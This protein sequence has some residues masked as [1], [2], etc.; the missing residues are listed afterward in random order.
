MVRK[1]L[2]VSPTNM[3]TLEKLTWRPE[4]RKVTQLKAWSKNPRKITK[5]AF[6]KLK[7]R[8]VK[9]GFHDVV[10]IDTDNTV[11]SGNQRK[12]ALVE[13]GIK[14]VTVLLPSRKLTEEERDKV[15]LESNTNDGEWNFEDLQ[16][17]DIELLTDIGFDQSELEKIWDKPSEVAEDNFDVEKELQKIKVPRTKVGDLI[18]MGRHKLI[19]GDCQDP[20][21]LKRLFFGEKAAMIYSDPPYNINL[22]YDKGIGGKRNFGGHVND[23]RTDKEYEEFLRKTMAAALSVANKDSHWFYY[24]SQLYVWQIQVLFRELGMENKSICIWAKNVANPVP[25]IAFNRSYEPVVYGTRGK[26]FLAKKINSLTEFMNKE[27]GTGNSS[28]D[29]IWAIKRMPGKDMEHT[30]SKPAELHQKAILR[31]TKPGDIVLDSFSGSASTMIAGE[32]LG[33]R[34]YAVELEPIYCDLAVKR[35][36]ALTG[37]KAKI[38]PNE[39]A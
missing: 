12:K 2:T 13:L 16:S 38:Y 39:K 22:K 8:I 10:K 23:N 36:E 28:F 32:Q 34:V 17:F 21:V 9:R 25:S 27:I 4:R 3:K 37:R 7:E 20:T 11:L 29:D 1:P 30:T 5:P 15:A 26:P 33:R 35:Y 18:V 31:C 24:C 6:E 19:C 14:E